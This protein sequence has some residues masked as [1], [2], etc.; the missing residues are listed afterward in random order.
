MDD[1]GEQV[2]SYHT[3]DIRLG[4]RLNDNIELAIVGQNL[5]DDHHLEFIPEFIDTAPTEVERGVYG[6]ITLLTNKS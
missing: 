2:D 3:L 4:W 1:L 6:K 5:I